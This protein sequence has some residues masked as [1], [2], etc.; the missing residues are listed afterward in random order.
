MQDV[1]LPAVVE[2]SPAVDTT[3]PPNQNS[4]VDIVDVM[5]QFFKDLFAN[6]PLFENNASTSTTSLGGTAVTHLAHPAGGIVEHPLLSAASPRTSWGISG[7]EGMIDLQLRTAHATALPF[8]MPQLLNAYRS[9]LG[10]A[11]SGGVSTYQP[12]IA[13]ERG[14]PTKRSRRTQV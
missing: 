10:V 6:G 9:D 2:A 13:A 8:V 3:L 5:D 7:S 4:E 11:G 1:G 14:D 12:P